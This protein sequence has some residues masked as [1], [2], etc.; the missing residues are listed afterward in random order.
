ML[1]LAGESEAR[2]E[3]D[4]SLESYA[5]VLVGRVRQDHKWRGRKRSQTYDCEKKIG[6]LGTRESNK[7]WGAAWSGFKKWADPGTLQSH[8]L[9][10]GLQTLQVNPF[11]G[12]IAFSC[13]PTQFP[14]KG[15]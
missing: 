13:C 9:P 5:K 15:L 3:D 12:R 7:A 1:T 8:H 10:A 14:V 2:Q 11:H 4:G 6:M